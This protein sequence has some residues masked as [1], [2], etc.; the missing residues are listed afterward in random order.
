[1]KSKW[2]HYGGI[3]MPNNVS[4]KNV[5]DEIMEKL[6]QRAKRHHRSLQGELLTILEEAT[7][8]AQSSV[9]QAESQLKSLDL[10]T[11]SESTTWLRELRDAC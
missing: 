3:T 11:D 10:V 6:R 8:H 1:M 7:G 9:D 2:S 4:V 5:P